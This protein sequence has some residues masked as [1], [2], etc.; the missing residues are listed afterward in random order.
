M[1]KSKMLLQNWKYSTLKWKLFW[2]ERGLQ[3]H[4]VVSIFNLKYFYSCTFTIF[5]F[6]NNGFLSFQNILNLLLKLTLA[7]HLTWESIHYLTGHTM[8]SG[9]SF[10]HCVCHIVPYMILG[11][12]LFVKYNHMYKEALNNFPFNIMRE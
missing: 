12:L 10:V 11:K 9:Y 7:G 4:V 5:L 6:S 3:T 8:I 1:A 2:W